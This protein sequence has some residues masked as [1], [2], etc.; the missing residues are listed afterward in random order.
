MWQN[1]RA[2]IILVTAIAVSQACFWFY[3]ESGGKGF[4]LPILAFHAI[5]ISTGMLI[6]R[7]YTAI[8][9]KATS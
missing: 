7:S 9:N 3:R 6:N 2:T 8:R 4:F 1:V 5:C